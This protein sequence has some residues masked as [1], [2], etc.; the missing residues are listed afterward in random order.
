TG[1]HLLGCP[2]KMSHL[3][4]PHVQAYAGLNPEVHRSSQLSNSNGFPHLQL[5]QAEHSPGVLY[6]AGGLYCSSFWLSLQFPTPCRGTGT[7]AQLLLVFYILSGNLKY[8]LQTQACLPL[9]GAECLYKLALRSVQCVASTC[10]AGAVT[11]VRSVLECAFNKPTLF[12]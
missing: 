6:P 11:L 12:N 7:H 9:Q 10:A 2:S 5:Q 4:L 1:S 8:W 3:L